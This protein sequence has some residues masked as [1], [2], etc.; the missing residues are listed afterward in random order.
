MSPP[1]GASDGGSFN[2]HD[3][4]K[5]SASSDNKGDIVGKVE[6]KDEVLNFKDDSLGDLDG[7]MNSDTF[8]DLMSDLNI[9]NDFIDQFE[10]N[11]KNALEDLGNV[12]GSEFGG[13]VG[14]IDD[15]DD[16]FLTPDDDAGGPSGGGGGRPNQMS[17]FVVI[18][19]LQ[20]QRYSAATA[21][22]TG[23]ADEPDGRLERCREVE[24]HG[25]A[26]SAAPSNATARDGTL[27]HAASCHGRTSDARPR[28]AAAHVPR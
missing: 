24:D 9:P 5:Y 16:A 18:V 27:R 8:N 26:A 7:I 12:I 15:K 28:S 14:G 21:A 25:P 22:A 2:N 6:P 10:F 13:A 17:G 3:F 20:R 1:G 23:I 4:G 19:F 11:D